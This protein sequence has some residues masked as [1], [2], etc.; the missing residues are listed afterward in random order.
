MNALVPPMVALLALTCSVADGQQPATTGEDP[1]VIGQVE[2]FGYALVGPRG[3]HYVF[4]G[5]AMADYS[6]SAGTRRIVTM[7]LE[8]ASSDAEF[9]YYRELRE[10]HRWALARKAGAEGQFGVWIQL[11]SSGSQDRPKWQPF[12]RARLEQPRESGGLGPP[13]LTPGNEQGRTRCSP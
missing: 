9:V 3:R 13:G 8:E 5:I 6:D 12:Q 10:G 4:G 2:H 1:T 7:Q 11:A